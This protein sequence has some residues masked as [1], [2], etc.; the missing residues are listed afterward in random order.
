M[1]YLLDTNA[2]AGIINSDQPEYL[3]VFNKFV[4][5]GTESIVISSLVQTELEAGLLNLSR[6]K[7]ARER[8][9]YIR[10][11][12]EFFLSCFPSLPYDKKAAHEAAKLM[13]FCRQN[14]RPLSD[15]DAC[16]AGHAISLGY[17][18]VSN[19]LKAFEGLNYP[20]LKWEDW[21]KTN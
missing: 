16:I 9:K 5:L 10:E 7:I 2:V 19:D 12:T 11:R 15:I 4:D 3:S 17:T 18:L 14:G 6:S 8:K 1:K 21:R 13:V 20:D